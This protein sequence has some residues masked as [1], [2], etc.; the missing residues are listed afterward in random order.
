M[1]RTLCFIATM[2]VFAALSHV[3]FSCPMRDRTFAYRIWCRGT[4]QP[5]STYARSILRASQLSTA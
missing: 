1:T 2:T 4:E 5:R 3:S